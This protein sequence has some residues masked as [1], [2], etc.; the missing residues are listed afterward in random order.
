VVTTSGEQNRQKKE[1][2]VDTE[3]KRVIMPQ[4]TPPVINPFDGNA[5]EA[6]LMIKDA[7]GAKITV[8][9]AGR[10]LSKAVLRKSLATG[11]DELILLEDD[12]FEELDS[13]ATVSSVEDKRQIQML[14]RWVPVLLRF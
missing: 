14:A 1:R 5:L 12:A 10:N 6:A 4:G 13:Y 11:A 2:S 9:S 3:A 7:Q 8:I